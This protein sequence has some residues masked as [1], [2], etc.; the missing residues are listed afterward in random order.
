MKK[1][2]FLTIAVLT[3]LFS[4]A[5]FQDDFDPTELSG[6]VMAQGAQFKS[7]SWPA[8]TASGNAITTSGVG[9]NSPARVLTPIVSKTGSTVQVCLNIWLMNANYNS[10]LSLPCATTMNIQFIKSTVTS[11][12]DVDVPANVLATIP[13]GVTLPASGGQTCF[14]FTFPASV[15]DANFRVLIT[16]QA[17]CNQSSNKFVIDNA[18]ISGVINTGCNNSTNSCG[19]SDN[20]CPPQPLSDNFV[21]AS[22]TENSWSGVLYG[23]NAAYPN[24]GVAYKTDVTGNDGD[25]NNNYSQ[26]SWSLMPGTVSPAG[27]AIVTVNSNGSFAFN[28]VNTS[29]SVITFQYNMCDNGLDNIAGNCDDRCAVST[30]TVSYLAAQQSL[31][32]KWTSF[33]ASVKSGY[34]TLSWTT[35]SELG[36]KGFEVERK[37]ANDAWKPIGFVASASGG[38]LSA[39]SLSY[40]FTDGEALGS[41]VRY[42]R[43]KEVSVD[44][45]Y[46]YSDISVVRGTQGGL[47]LLVY[48]NPARGG[49]TSISVPQGSESY[50]I[51]LQDVNGK[52][53]ASWKSTTG[54]TIPVTGVRSGFYFI[55]AQNMITGEK[56]VQKLMVP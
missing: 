40:R 44:N 17:G 8:G 45:Q 7:A 16:F 31:P 39:S 47:D 1:F 56:K 30:V 32:V 33:T 26:V 29:T 50:S 14:Q 12:Q 13:G 35:G 46:T 18:Q 23:Q 25:A 53:L 4:F 38:R 43:L 3:S 41:E 9:G 6:W 36:S 2:T 19:A 10:V 24:M 34:A 27:T 55:A 28:R 21:M 37:T 54:G 48:P 11:I 49:N 51:S 42:Y 52:V 20:N 5:Q 15:T 22:V